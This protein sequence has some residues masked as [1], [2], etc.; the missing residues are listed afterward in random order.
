MASEPLE[1]RLLLDEHYPVWLA[2]RLYAA[3]LDTIAVLGRPDLCGTDDRRVLEV[4]VAEGKL[5][6]VW[7]LAL[8]E[9]G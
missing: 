9:E 3:G 1:L 4:A 7:G 6:V 5:P 2:Q 8:P